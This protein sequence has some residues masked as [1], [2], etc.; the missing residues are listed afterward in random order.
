MKKKFVFLLA[1][2][3]LALVADIALG[4]VSLPLSEVWAALTGQSQDEVY[5]EIILNHRLPK[6][7]TAILAGAALSVAGVLMQTLFQNPL[8]GPDVLGVTS[9][10]SLGVALLTMGTSALPLW[11]LTGWGQ[12]TAAVAGAVCVLLLV[13][14]VSIKVPN[15]VS[16][17]IIGMMFGSFAGA[18]VSILQSVSN[19]DTLKLF[20]TWTFGS[21][22]AVGWDY[23]LVMAPVIGI[24]LLIALLLQKQLNVFLLGQNYA[25]GL[26]ISVSRLRLFT[27]LATALLA[28]TSTAFTG[29]I[30]FI[31]I[32]MPHVAR[33]LFR[34]SNH[35][36]ILPASILCGA[37][38][39]LLCDLISGLPGTQTTLPINAVTALFGAPI[40]VWI[41]A[42][43]SH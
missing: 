9:G 34:T 23:M 30:A 18:V 16:L 39:M 31:G 29:P 13:I 42:K 33:G 10:A 28:G 14:V 4:S 27:I 36:I 12:V 35:H 32:T 26:G 24:G 37:V 40:I 20:V 15:A 2:L 41:I 21:L 19:P 22:S 5:R 3:L 1:L 7:L 8:A 11:M 6:A 25:S 38:T 43:K 17:L